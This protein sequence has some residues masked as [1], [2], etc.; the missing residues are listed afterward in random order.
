MQLKIF[1]DESGKKNNLPMLMGA[2]SVPNKIY[3]IQEL[4]NINKDLQE[5]KRNYHFTT[6]SGD[7]KMK[8]RII[9]LFKVI[10]PYL[11]LCR[12]NILQYN[13]DN[14]IGQDFNRMIYS[15]F[16]ERVFYGLLR[17]NGQLM[18]INADIFMENATEYKDLSKQ[19]KEQLNI[20]SLY[21]GE[22]FKI[23]NC[24]MVP[25]YTEI[26]VELIDII[27]GIIRV[28]LQ[29]NTISQK[30]TKASKEKILLTNELLR[31]PE[32]YNFFKSIKYFE[33]NSKQ[34][35]KEINFKNY[36]D[37]YIAETVI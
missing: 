14:D 13:K 11:N 16:P 24:Y 32:V 22:D 26:G 18:D 35:L 12:A 6:Y 5:N 1:F 2:I 3:N 19:F 31:M 30:T 21:R 4:Q 15:K 34:S 9:N 25:K 10:S 37:A 29:F 17:G 8:E 27:L 23:N 28:I 7:Y 36:L 20:Q 33:W